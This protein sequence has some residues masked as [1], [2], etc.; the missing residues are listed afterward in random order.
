[1]EIQ[2]T[3]SV[4]QKKK[5]F[6]VDERD[7][8]GGAIEK[9]TKLEEIKPVEYGVTDFQQ[10][11][12]SQAQQTYDDPQQFVQFGSPIDDLRPRNQIAFWQ[13]DHMYAA[14]SEDDFTN[15]IIKLYSGKGAKH[16]DPR[17]HK[18]FVDSFKHHPEM[19]AHYTT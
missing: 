6:K 12:M 17:L 5:K 18:L 10:L 16:D 3:E 9:T 13:Y 11:L 19:L 7:P 2:E 4:G 8:V 1:M 15:D 14:H